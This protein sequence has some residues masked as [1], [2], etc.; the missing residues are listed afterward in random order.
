MNVLEGFI[1]AVLMLSVKIRLAH[2]D[3]LAK[4]DTGGMDIVAL[5]TY[6]KLQNS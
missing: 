3:A 4:A 6:M 2:T 1:A 5:V